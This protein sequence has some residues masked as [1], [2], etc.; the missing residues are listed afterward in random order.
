MGYEGEGYGKARIVE[1]FQGE[2]RECLDNAIRAAVH[3]SGVEE[4]TTLLITQIEVVTV[5]DPNVGSYKV[6][7]RPG[8]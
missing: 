4:G 8:G 3:A 1:E 5:G 6:T 2:S 7:V